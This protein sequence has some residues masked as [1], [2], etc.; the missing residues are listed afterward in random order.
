MRHTTHRTA[1]WSGL[2]TAL[3]VTLISVG[4]PLFSFHSL[5]SSAGTTAATAPSATSATSA[6]PVGATAGASG[7][8]DSASGQAVG[9]AGSAT[10]YTLQTVSPVKGTSV[11]VRW[12][13]CQSAITYAVNLTGLPAAKRA[14]M[15]TLVQASFTR[16]AAADGMTYR[17]KGTTTFVPQNENIAQ[18][19][20]EIVVAVVSRT[21]TDLDLTASS[22][23][24]GGVIWDSW[25]GGQ[26]NGAAVV[27]GYVV[28]NSSTLP[29]LKPGFGPGRTTGNVLLHE[30]GH[31]TGL[32]HTAVK[33]EQ[34]NP[35]LTDAAPNG[36][37][38]GDLAGLKRVG[39][40]AGCITIPAGV[41]SPDLN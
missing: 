30:L 27:R 2:L 26:G 33:G 5:G 12:N 23:G 21:A 8:R 1:R 13:P 15:L 36:Y 6:Q 10:G 41:T 19:P 29:L 25:Y 34:M 28:L 32:E 17:Y 37:A 35:V 24:Y 31:A 9:A 16:L 38:A 20:A 11:V 3:A 4:A 39:A 18:E 14:A 40:A 22:L 7:A